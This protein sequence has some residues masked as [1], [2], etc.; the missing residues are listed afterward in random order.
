MLEA[1]LRLVKSPKHRSLVGLGYADAFEAADHVPEILRFDPIGLEG[2]EGAMV[3]G[4]RVKGAPNLD[5]LPP[6][7]GILLVEFGFDD[8]QPFEDLES[9]EQ[10]PVVPEAFREEYRSLVKAHV[11]TL[12]QSCAAVRVVQVTLPP[13]A[14]W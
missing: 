14:S 12:A 13:L 10:I 11:D 7:R 3:D 2:F 6:G 1:T 5:L 9:G 8:A 4:L